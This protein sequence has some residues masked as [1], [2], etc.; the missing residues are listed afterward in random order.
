MSVT[1]LDELVESL[2]YEGYALYPYTPGTAKNST[3][4]PFGIV[5]PPAYA[6][7][8]AATF[9]HLRLECALVASPDLAREPNPARPLGTPVSATV[10][11]LQASGGR[12]QAAERRVEL[13]GP[14]ADP[15]EFSFDGLQGRAS[16]ELDPPED[17]LQRVRVCVQ[18]TTPLADPD[19]DRA[20]ALRASLLS[21]HVIATA[22]G[23]RFL[24]PLER[25]DFESVN[26]F[27]VLATPTDDTVLGATIVLPDHPQIAPQ[28]RGNLFDGTEIEEALLLHVHALPDMEREAIADQDPAVRAMVERAAATTP[29]DLFDLHGVMHPTLPG[30]MSDVEPSVLADAEPSVLPDAKPDVLS[31]AEPGALSD[32]E[33]P[34]PHPAFEGWRPKEPAEWR[35]AEQTEPPKPPADLPYFP[36]YAEATAGGVTFRRGDRVRLRPQ[37]EGDPI[38]HMVAGRTATIEKL[39]HDVDNRLYFAVTVDG[40]PGQELLRDSGRFLYFFEGEVEPA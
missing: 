27:P 35:P 14:G 31:D 29:E 30:V 17:G 39:L 4:T 23:S 32:A 13:P 10:R 5:Y 37:H 24:S 26:T 21:T 12:H 6:A 1:D 38:D 9:D 19:I 16:L 2:L 15:V 36:G 11:F 25:R 7:G 3:P 34:Q 28:S 33:H 40:D 22:P 8:N 18:N 20:A